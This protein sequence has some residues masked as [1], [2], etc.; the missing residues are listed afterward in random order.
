MWLQVNAVVS[1]KYFKVQLIDTNLAQQS[2]TDFI[3]P[4]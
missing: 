4:E 1:N 3:R 2:K